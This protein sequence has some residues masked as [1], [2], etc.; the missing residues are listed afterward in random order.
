MH[1]RLAGAGWMPFP[2]YIDTCE[3]CRCLGS[4]RTL[5]WQDQLRQQ[6]R[7]RGWLRVWTGLAPASAGWLRK[8]SPSAGSVCAWP[9]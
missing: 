4:S 8:W 7:W 5:A 1:A 2:L 9:T 3:T 6:S